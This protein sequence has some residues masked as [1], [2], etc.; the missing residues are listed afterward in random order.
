MASIDSPGASSGL[1]PAGRVSFFDEQARR[2]RGTWRLSFACLLVASGVGVVLS[3][4]V[5]PLL[6]LIG[7]ELLSLAAGLGLAPAVMHGAVRSIGRW[8]AYHLGNFDRLI[9]SLDHVNGLGDLGVLLPPLAQLSP[10]AVPAL[11]AAAIVW[12]ALRALVM[13]AGGED[14][15]HRLNARATN[16]ADR[17]E[18]Q[19]A[20]IIEEVAIAAGLP[21]PRLFVIDSPIVNAAAVG[22]T[23]K[24]AAVLVTR[25]LLDSL[26]RAET[27]AV[28][29]HMIASIGGGDIKVTA[30]ILAVFQTFGFFLTVLD[31]PFRW[32]AWRALGGLVFVS[33]LPRPSP[34]T[35]VRAGDSIEASLGGDTMPDVERM[36]AWVPFQWLRYMLLAPL[37]PPMLISMLLKLVLFLWTAFFLGPPL[38][39][40]WRNRRYIADAKA[41]ELTRDPDALARALTT[42]AGSG[43]P[44]GGELREYF[45]ISAPATASKSALADR[46][47]MSAALHPPL[48]RRV[49]RLV[50]LGA[51]PV[52]GAEPFRP[53]RWLRGLPPLIALV[54]AALLVLLVPLFAAL[55]VMIF[56]LTALAMT[57]ALAAGLTLVAGLFAG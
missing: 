49:A 47:T 22:R 31:L 40:L 46:Q 55:F 13:R 57:L 25:G 7:G 6:L 36:F 43:V 23:H 18:H 51:S 54:V 53:F 26:D 39:W 27:S 45:F 28:V 35:V 37:L 56:Y 14:L 33:V 42:I 15:I 48:A 3:A 19:L 16:P 8:A 5:T 30:S 17:E 34:E 4:A 12:V 52:G 20:N 24:D 38:S 32:S 11:I 29:G 21:A 2:R 1:P 44:P 50:A 9:G 41:V 10:V